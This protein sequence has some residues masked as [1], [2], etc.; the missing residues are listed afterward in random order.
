M[1]KIGCK[2][3]YYAKLT[4]DDATGVTYETP[5]HI[6]GLISLGVKP[7]SNTGTLYA[8]NAP[9][10]TATTLGE[11]TIDLDTADLPVE[12]EAALLGHTV[13][14]GVIT[15]SKDD[16]APYVAIMFEGTKANGGTRYKK[17]LKG[18][19]A[20]PEDSVETKKENISFQT[21]KISGK[22]VARTY[23][24][25]WARTADTD[26]TGYEPDTGAAWYTSVE[27]TA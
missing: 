13:V 3:F 19:F 11:I 10:E 18:K 15:H 24:G 16:I 5:K 17:L 4:K 25:E 26:G 7:A 27:P 22:F 8:D 14:K 2:N 20:E 23:D 21:R 6:A 12:D 1:S 9:L